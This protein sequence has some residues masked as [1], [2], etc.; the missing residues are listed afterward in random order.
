[1]FH[2]RELNTK[3]NRLHERALRIVCKNP[4][5]TFQQLLGLDKSQ[6]IHHRN[7]QKLAIEMFKINKMLVPTLLPELFPTYENK[8]NL[9]SQRCWQSSNVRTVNFG[10]EALLYR[11]QK[12]WQL[13]PGSIKNSNSL[14]EFK[15]KI[16][17]WTPIGCSCRLCKTYVHNLGFI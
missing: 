14:N 9:K 15:A 8:Y 13:L 1:M 16:K 5:L 12:T 7:L 17:N 6:C 3:K 2:S 4:Q 11:G 10:I